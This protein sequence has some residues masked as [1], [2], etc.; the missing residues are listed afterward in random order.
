ML[1]YARTRNT[2]TGHAYTLI[3]YCLTNSIVSARMYPVIPSQDLNG[4][5][6]AGEQID[7]VIGEFSITFDHVQHKRLLW[8]QSIEL[9][10]ELH[11]R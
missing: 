2:H 8:Y 4:G 5:L 3:I 11:D 10:Y 1:Q 9:D 6:D 7:A